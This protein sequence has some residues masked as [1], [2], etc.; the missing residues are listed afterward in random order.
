M[1]KDGGPNEEGLERDIGRNIE[2][3][4]IGYEPKV[5]RANESVCNISQYSKSVVNTVGNASGRNVPMLNL[6]SPNGIEHNSDA[7]R[8]MRDIECQTTSPRHRVE[9]SWLDGFL[10]GYC[11]QPN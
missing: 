6:D 10:C 9:R 5:Q 2:D 7:D 11:T 4:N 3:C 1:A 8:P